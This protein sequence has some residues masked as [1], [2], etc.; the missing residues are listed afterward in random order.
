MERREVL[1]GSAAA[2]V[3][4]LLYGRAEA[5]EAP[6]EI[7]AAVERFR[8]SVPSNFSQDYVEH[9]VIPF[10]LTSFY[11]GE[12]PLLPMIDINFSKENALPTDLW[13]LIYEGWQPTPLKAS[14]SSYRVSKSAVT[15]IYASGFIS[16]R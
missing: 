16:R 5:A 12:R 14:L 8:A 1:F 3:A 9:M 13:S 10:F 2:A 4:G 7:V 6:P 11:E 15:T